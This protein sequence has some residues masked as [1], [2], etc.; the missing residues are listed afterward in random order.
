MGRS[1]PIRFEITS[2]NV[3]NSTVYEAVATIPGFGP[4]P[5][6]KIEGGTTFSTRS[7]VTYACNNRA[8]SLGL[9]PVINYTESAATTTAT[10]NATGNR[11]T[12]ARTT[13][14]KNTKKRVTT[15]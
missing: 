11:K 15:R 13:T 12:V 6:E 1:K 10:T 8:A 4:A 5:V 3:N 7:A 14:T 9:T 2:R